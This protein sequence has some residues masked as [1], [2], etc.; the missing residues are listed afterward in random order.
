MSKP[1][2][3]GD[4]ITI[5]NLKLMLDDQLVMIHQTLETN[6][7]L[8]KHVCELEKANQAI[9]S[10]PTNDLFMGGKRPASNETNS[11]PL[12]EPLIEHPHDAPICSVHNAVALF[13]NRES[14]QKHMKTV[15]SPTKYDVESLYKSTGCVQAMV[16]SSTFKNV[17]LL[18]I[19][20]N[21][22][23]IAYDTDNNH[24]EALLNAAIQF[25]V[26]ENLFCCFFTFE[27]VA[28]LMAFR[29]KMDALQ[30]GWFVFDASLVSMMIFETW[31]VS[32]I[33]YLHGNSK[34][35]STSSSSIFRS[36]RLFRLMRSGRVLR[37]LRA[38][39]E[40]M[41]LV[42]AMRSAMRSVASTLAMMVLLIYLFA[43]ILTQNLR[44]T[45][46]A[47]SDGFESVPGS[48]LTLMKC[49]LFPDQQSILDSM[50][51][52]SITAYI[53][54]V[55]F[56]VIG[57]MALMNL[58]LG[59]LCEVV[60]GVSKAEKDAADVSEV[61]EQLAT[62]LP[63]TASGQISSA[64]FRNL[65]M[66]PETCKQ[67]ASLGVDLPTLVDG[68]DFLYAESNTLGIDEFV[69]MVLRFR[70]DAPLT[71]KD[72]VDLRRSIQ[73]EARVLFHR[74]SRGSAFLN[75]QLKAEPAPSQT[76]STSLSR[77]STALL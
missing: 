7:A 2:P 28:R 6:K 60:A 31:I 49:G 12:S 51:G 1:T 35:N 14:V 76:P 16:R 58:L 21:T 17:S 19:I 64:D 13:P 33:I 34:T 30:D 72:V 39:P 40:L 66:E 50:E 69:Q 68:A 42:Q 25:V 4:K 46:I 22:L 61:K 56:L 43:I 10:Q 5:G 48:M 67:F 20:M 24:A 45:G 55:V 29:R 36:L 38:C 3:L 52:T 44:A 47:S 18:V 53:S 73:R 26:A 65:I 57:T 74:L 32:A 70:G 11:T 75:S 63:Y 8:M 71:V 59:V 41:V 37:I 62:F 23:W 27:I 77:A 15:L 9:R 54:L